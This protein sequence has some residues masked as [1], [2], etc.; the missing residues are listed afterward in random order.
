LRGLSP[1]NYTIFA[2]ESVDGEAYY[3]P[4]FL[5]SYEGQGKALHVT[6]GDRVRVQIKT[7]PAVE[8]EP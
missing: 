2:W 7:I 8:D 1:G 6:E 5:K 3:N 4:E